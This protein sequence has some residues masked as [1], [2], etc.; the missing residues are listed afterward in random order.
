MHRY[1]YN[2]IQNVDNMHINLQLHPIFQ[3][4]IFTDPPNK[5]LNVSI[6]QFV[7]SVMVNWHTNFNGGFEQKFYIEYKIE[8]KGNWRIVE[9]LN[10]TSSAEV[11]WQITGLRS[12]QTYFFRMFARNSLGE[13][14]R[15]DMQ[16]VKTKGKSSL[17]K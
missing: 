6:K 5:P 16:I 3:F 15:T 17:I 11:S 4:Y 12:S 7:N 13:S 1:Q 8:G 9:S 10:T 14:S 2:R